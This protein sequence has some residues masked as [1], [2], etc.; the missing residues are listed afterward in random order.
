MGRKA[1]LLRGLTNTQQSVVFLL[2]LPAC[3][4]HC[5]TGGWAAGVIHCSS[6][7]V[8]HHTEQFT[9]VLPRDVWDI[10]AYYV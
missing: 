3:A 2:A 4:L 7:K 10:S 6:S 9:K 5:P 8:P 1:Q